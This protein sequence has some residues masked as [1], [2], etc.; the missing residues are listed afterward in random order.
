MEMDAIINAW[1]R[2]AERHDDRNVKFLRSLKMK[3]QPAVDRAALRLHPEAFSIIDYLQCAN[4]C[5]TVSPTFTLDD[6]TQIAAD[7]WMDAGAFATEHLKESEDR[8][9]MEPESLPCPFLADDSR[10]K[11]TRFDPHPVP[12]IP[13]RISMSSL[14]GRTCTPVMP[15]NAP[16]SSISSKRCGRSD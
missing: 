4:C 15:R 8:G 16:P 11:S 6:I 7:L 5:K 3:N 12:S 1:K 9:M 14:P 13:T 10:C 2:N